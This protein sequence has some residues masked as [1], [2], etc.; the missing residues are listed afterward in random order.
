VNGE[1]MD[2]WERHSAVETE[3]AL[4]AELDRVHQELTRV[5]PGRSAAIR[6]MRDPWVIAL[7]SAVA[8]GLIVFILGSLLGIGNS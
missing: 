2:E 8:G 5:V 3:T 1:R 4:K 6:F 7:G